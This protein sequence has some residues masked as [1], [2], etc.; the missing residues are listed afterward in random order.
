MSVNANQECTTAS[1]EYFMKST[2][3]DNHSPEG[4]EYN[5]QRNHEAEEEDHPDVALLNWV[6][7]LPD[8]AAGNAGSFLIKLVPPEGRK[9]RPQE[10]EEVAKCW[11]AT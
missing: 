10:P 7:C 4:V 2:N 5:T 9:Y 1:Y 3:R 11:K 6:I 8:N